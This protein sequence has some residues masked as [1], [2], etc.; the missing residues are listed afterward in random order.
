MKKF[1]LHLMNK[2]FL[3][4]N[5]SQTLAFV[6]KNPIRNFTSHGKFA[7]WKAIF[8]CYDFYIRHVKEAE[9]YIMNFLKREYL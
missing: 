3:I 9:N 5:D 7:R 4:K 2:K 6:L 1:E 8:S